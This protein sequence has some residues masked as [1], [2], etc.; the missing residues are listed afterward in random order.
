MPSLHTDHQNQLPCVPANGP[1]CLLVVDDHANVLS[2]LAEL[3]EASGYRVLR[4]QD[5][6]TALALMAGDW[7][8][9]LI[10]SD[11]SMPGLDG[12]ALYA[13]VK[14]SPH[15][16]DTPVIFISGLEETVTKWS[17]LQKP[18]QGLPLGSF[19]VRIASRVN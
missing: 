19:C 12:Y 1:A 10:L 4:A 16:R 11:I 15:L 18:P 6:P 14:N 5:G 3:L 13:A 8:P 2:M 9:D 17:F 7:P